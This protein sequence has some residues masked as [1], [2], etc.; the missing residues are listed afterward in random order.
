MLSLVG[1]TAVL[2][3]ATPLS[4]TVTDSSETDGKTYALNVPISGAATGAETLTISVVSHTYDIAGN[5]IESIQVTSTVNL[6]AIADTISPTV[7]L[8]HDHPDLM[9]SGYDTIRITATFSEAMSPTPV[10]YTHLTL[11]TKRIV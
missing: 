9:V 7:A 11:P 1:G 3:S 5:P 4:F 10:S 2:G 6:N 8:T